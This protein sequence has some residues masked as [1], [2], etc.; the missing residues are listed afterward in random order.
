MDLAKEIQKKI[1]EV[2]PG[3]M[4]KI[5]D[6]LCDNA[7]FEAIVVAKEFEGISL[8]KQHQMV[9]QALKEDFQTRLHALGLKTYSITQWEKMNGKNAEKNCN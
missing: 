2:L 7:H 8:I 4:V 3:A 9:M 6:P 1:L 5:S